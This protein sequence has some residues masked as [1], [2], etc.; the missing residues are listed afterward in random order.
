LILILGL[1]CASAALPEAVS[2]RSPNFGPSASASGDSQNPFVTPDGRF[3]LFTST[4]NNLATADGTNAFALPLSRLNVYRR[5]RVSGS[6]ELVSIN[7]AGT[8]GG[9][10]DANGMGISTN[11]RYALF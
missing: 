5:D 7:F 2:V 8:A 10:A 4:A 1:R 11:G 3:V 9:N 6:N